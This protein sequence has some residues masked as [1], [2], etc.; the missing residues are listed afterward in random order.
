MRDPFIVAGVVSRFPDFVASDDMVRCRLGPD[1]ELNADVAA[2]A[3]RNIITE[4]TKFLKRVCA[5]LSVGDVLI[6][7]APES[8]NTV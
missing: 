7:V 2:E 3:V 1:D 4:R 6:T 8:L 5:G